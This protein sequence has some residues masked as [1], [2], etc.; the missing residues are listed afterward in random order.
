[1][2][3]LQISFNLRQNSGTFA[4]KPNLRAACNLSINAFKT[5]AEDTVLVW[6]SD[7]IDFS[8]AIKKQVIFL[9]TDH[10][11]NT[12]YVEL[13]KLVLW[14]FQKLSEQRLKV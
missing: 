1:M 6:N 5:S 14:S 11:Y 8:V 7:W 13:T 9:T 4:V 3:I 12:F 10:L 2:F